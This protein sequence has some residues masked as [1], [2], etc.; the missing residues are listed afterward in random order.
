MRD[1]TLAEWLGF[2]AEHVGMYDEPLHEWAAD[3]DDMPAPYWPAAAKHTLDLLGHA[4]AHLPKFPHEFRV[5]VEQA[6]STIE[7]VVMPV[8]KREG[9]KL[10]TI[11]RR[12]PDE[13]YHAKMAALAMR[14]PDGLAR[15]ADRA[16]AIDRTVNGE[17]EPEGAEPTQAELDAMRAMQQA[18]E[19]NPDLAHAS[20]P[21]IYKH[22]IT[23]GVV[24]NGE[25]YRPVSFDAWSRAYSRAK[26][27]AEDM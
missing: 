11:A 23:E 2:I 15:L 16:R 6:F 25:P 24:V 21:A 5:E 20:R 7:R 27:K 13:R 8:A 10:W 1:N 18:I 26:A 9:E 12:D 22:I 17:D 4:R 19:D 14:L 3:H